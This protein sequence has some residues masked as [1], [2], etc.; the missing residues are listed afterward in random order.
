MNP[1]FSMKLGMERCMACGHRWIDYEDVR[2]ECFMCGGTEISECVSLR[3]IKQSIE[4]LR[5]EDK[6]YLDKHAKRTTLLKQLYREVAELALARAQEIYGKV[7]EHYNRGDL[8][9]RVV[10]QLIVAFRLF[11]ELGVH[12]SAAA[13]AY[14][15]AVG[16]TERGIDKEVRSVDDL[17]D[18]VAARQ[19]FLRLGA[20]EWEAAVNL[21]IGQKA[22]ATVSNDAS[23]LQSMMQVAV[24][25]LY[26]ARDYYGERRATKLFDRIQFD[27]ERAT[28][29]LA[30][31]AQGASQIEAARITAQSSVAHAEH[32]RRGLESLGQSVQFGL[33]ALGEHIENWGGSVSRA[34]Q[35]A[36]SSMSANMTNA[37]YTLASTSKAKGRSLD[38]RMS[39]VGLLIAN[40]AKEIPADFFKPVKELGAKVA[41]G[42]VTTASSTDITSDPAMVRMSE[43]VLQE[44]KKS[45]ESLRQSGEP[46]MKV[47]GTML[48]TIVNQGMSE[49]AE[50]MQNAEA[51]SKS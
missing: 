10:D 34:L 43:S 18:L 1:K 40:T 49:P 25:H 26:K 45:E 33:S 48:D 21:H 30:T 5:K 2:T 14:M 17:S 23:L 35:A 4:A 13:I 19:W 47:T 31:Y 16:Y 37:M 41:M 24:W 11:S 7:K 42:A 12:R 36:S 15:T 46:S 32:I 27:I 3:E 44:A 20:K 39:D 9:D 28:H 22:M 8:S 6:N 29:L 38:K 50:R 51:E